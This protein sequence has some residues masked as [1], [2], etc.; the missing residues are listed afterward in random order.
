M[1][2]DIV[3]MPS[4]YI[5]KSTLMK[6]LDEWLDEHETK[7]IEIHPVRDDEFLV[8]LY[9]SCKETVIKDER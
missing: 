3:E 6:L 7:K 9:R 5:A 4:F 1:N 2:R 8:Y